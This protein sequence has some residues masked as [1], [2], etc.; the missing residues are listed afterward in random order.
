VTLAKGITVPNGLAL[1]ATHVYFT[2]TG[3]AAG[4]GSLNIVPR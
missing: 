2:A 3:N 4:R 1:D